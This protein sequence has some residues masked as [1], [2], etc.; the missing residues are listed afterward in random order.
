MFRLF[1][2]IVDVV[3]FASEVFRSTTLRSTAVISARNRSTDTLIEVLTPYNVL[4]NPDL[5]PYMKATYTMSKNHKNNLL[6][7]M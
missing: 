6:L 2:V 3:A 4:E 5:P 7:Q 1:H